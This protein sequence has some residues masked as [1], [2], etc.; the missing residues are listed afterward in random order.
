M[1][2]TGK[3]AG[4]ITDMPGACAGAPTP[5]KSGVAVA[6]RLILRSPA[7]SPFETVAFGGLL[8]MRWL[9]VSKDRRRIATTRARFD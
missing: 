6:I 7:T 1:M 9:G 4:R 8:R 2:K 3:I 5:H